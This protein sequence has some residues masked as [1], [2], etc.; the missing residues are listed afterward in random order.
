[1]EWLKNNAGLLIEILLA[2]FI[3]SNWIWTNFNKAYKLKK[4]SEDFHETVKNHTKQIAEMDIRHGEDYKEISNKI[5]G[6][7]NKLDHFIEETKKDNQVILRDK[8][9]DV[10]KLTLQKGYIL[11]KD[12]KN[13]HY[14]LERYLANGGN[15]YVT[16]EIKPRMEDFKVFLSDEDAE[17]YF[18][19]K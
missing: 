6:L 14:A 13:Y 1:M 4:S 15:S 16:D 8:I 9:Y 7:T 3:I 2:L 19:R 18:N 11:E 17:E 10:Y 5:D 12:S